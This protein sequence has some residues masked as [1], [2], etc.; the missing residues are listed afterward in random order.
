MA[1]PLLTAPSEWRRVTLEPR[2]NSGYVE[3]VASG[4][5]P[6]TSEP[7]YWDGDIPWITPKEVSRN[8]GGLFVSQTERYL[9]SEGLRASAAKLQPKGSVLMTKRAPVGAV[10]VNALPMATNQGFLCFQC[11]SELDPTYLAHWLKINRPYLDKV[12]NGSTYPEL[13]AGDLFEF[14]MAVPPRP[15]QERILAVVSALDFVR[16]IGGALERA[17]TSSEGLV[18]SHSKLSRIQSIRGRLLP[19]LFS[20]Q[21]SPPDTESVSE[22]VRISVG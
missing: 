11:G 10:A 4:G 16:G 20:G 8:G 18:E 1:E 9:T 21:I 2:P 3:A 22:A 14:E 15:L 12:A 6:R 5:T 13:Y 19:L 7:R 17:A